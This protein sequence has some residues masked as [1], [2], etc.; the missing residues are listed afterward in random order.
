M[1]QHT[2]FV[3]GN[4]TYVAS[5]GGKGGLAMPPSK[6]LLIGEKELHTHVPFSPAASLGTSEGDAH[7]IRNDA[8]EVASHS[9]CG[10]R[11]LSLRCLE[12]TGDDDAAMRIFPAK[13]LGFSVALRSG[14]RTE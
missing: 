13:A 11:Q 2:E 3:K 1:A 14:V 5:F 4:K 8:G 10:K 12:D 9:R 7:I 6:Q